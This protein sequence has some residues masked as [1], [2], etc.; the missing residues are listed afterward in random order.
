[1]PARQPMVAGRFYPAAPDALRR[2]VRRFLAVRADTATGNITGV[3]SGTVFQPWGCML[4]HAGYVFSG[5]VAGATLAGLSLPRRLVILCPNH[6]GRGRELGVWPAG[7]WLTPLGAVPVD[8]S[9]ATALVDSGGGFAPDVQS[10]LGE[11]S[12]EVLLPFLQ[13]VLSEES[14][15]EDRMVMV[16]VCVGTRHPGALVRAG[17]ALAELLARPENANVGIVVSSD[18]NHYEDVRRTKQKDALALEQA[19]AADADGLLHMV[20][21]A[22]ISMCGAAPL[23]LALYAG[24]RLGKVRVELAAYDTSATASG[25]AEHTVG[26]AGLRLLLARGQSPAVAA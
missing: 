17:A 24:T 23:A 18:M 9:L 4:P 13:V 16:P 22:N 6:T 26:Y 12:I 1:M 3:V 25:E 11:H 15:Q 2:E 5:A 10:H 8:E 21:A 20:G 7:V 14:E 19:L